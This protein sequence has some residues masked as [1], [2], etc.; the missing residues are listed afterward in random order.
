L[1]A[2]QFLRVLRAVTISYAP[3]SS[4]NLENSCASEVNFVALA[5]NHAPIAE[6]A[7]AMA[8]MAVSIKI[9]FCEV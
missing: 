5:D 1:S 9:I 4:I 6:N 3:Y 7:A 2:F 8:V